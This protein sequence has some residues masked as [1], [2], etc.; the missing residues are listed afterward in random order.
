MGDGRAATIVLSTSAGTAGY[1]VTV[2]N[3]FRPG[4]PWSSVVAAQP[5]RNDS[6]NETCVILNDRRSACGPNEPLVDQGDLIE[7]A[8]PMYLEANGLWT[9]T[10]DYLENG[11]P[12]PFTTSV[13]H[14]LGFTRQTA[15]LT[16]GLLSNGDVHCWVGS[17]KSDFILPE[18]AILHNVALAVTAYRPERSPPHRLRDTVG[19]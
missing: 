4:V 7:R 2:S 9:D 19:P 18:H 1:G 15:T 16:C 8:G 3:E 6:S 17:P 13:P 10:S 12:S 14:L 11:D 5:S